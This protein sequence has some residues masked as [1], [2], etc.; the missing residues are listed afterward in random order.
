MGSRRLVYRPDSNLWVSG[1]ASKVFVRDPFEENSTM[2]WV[3]DARQGP[4]ERRRCRR[5]DRN[6]HVERFFHAVTPC[7]R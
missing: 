5:T 4:I 3:G 2:P 7:L 1:F 6:R